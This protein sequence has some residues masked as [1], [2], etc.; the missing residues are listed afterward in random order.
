MT[1]KERQVLDIIKSNPTI[2]Q[3]Q[4]AKLLN[5]SRSTVAVHISSLENKGY[6]LG[7]GYI[8]KDDDYVLAIGACN[9][10]VYGKSKIKIKTHY[11][12]PASIYNSIGGVS[13]NI[14]CN[15]Y[16]LSGSG[17]LITAYS[18]D[19]YG[20]MIKQDCENNNIDISDSLL[21]KDQTSSIFMQ[22]MDDKNDMYLAICDMSILENIDPKYINEKR[23][24]I[25]NAKI[26]VLD[27]SLSD[28]TIKEIIK[29]CKDKVPIYVDPISDNYALKLRPYVKDFELIKPNKSELE[30]LTGIKIKNSDDYIKAGKQLIKKGV[31]KLVISMSKQGIIY[32]DDKKVIKRRLPEDKKMVNASGAGDSLMAG[33]IYGTINEFKLE[34]TLDF[35]M[36]CAICAIRSENTINENMS[37]ELVEEILK[38]KR[39]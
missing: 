20:K 22:I 3:E 7:K 6:L 30:S 14:I 2:R 33:I 16:K 34:K 11:D 10:D 31:K 18:D 32:M 15:Y 29:I 17:K 35:A 26:V 8:F 19:A 37:K 4:I 1:E 5:I 39:K 24:V 27:P 9:V 23:K 13:R 21:I 25:E 28:E 38:E 36:A 12:H